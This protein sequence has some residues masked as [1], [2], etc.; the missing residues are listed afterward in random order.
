[1]L[2]KQGNT[3]DEVI[4]VIDISDGYGFYIDGLDSEYPYTDAAIKLSFA[5]ID[6]ERGVYL[7]KGTDY[8]VTIKKNK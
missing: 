6:A 5:V 3:T 7:A 4:E 1:M 8:T 2:A